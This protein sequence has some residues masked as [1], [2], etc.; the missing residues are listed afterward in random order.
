M[1]QRFALSTA[2][3]VSAVLLSGTAFAQQSDTSGPAA[4]TDV[5]PSTSI[6]KEQG[7][8]EGRSTGAEQP[9]T[10]APAAAGHPGTEGMPGGK[11]GPAERAP[12]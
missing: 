4:G 12:K 6:Q 9:R 10:G 2:A 8:Q 1:S 5:R 3:M 11:S 7:G